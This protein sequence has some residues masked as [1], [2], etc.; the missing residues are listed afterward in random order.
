[1]QRIANGQGA[2]ISG[3]PTGNGILLW[4]ERVDGVQPKP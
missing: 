3:D 1:M 4:I 2:F